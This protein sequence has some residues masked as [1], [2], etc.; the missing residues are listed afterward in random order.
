MLAVAHEAGLAARSPA[1]CCALDPL[2]PMQV[3][4]HHPRP[5][6]PPPLAA[7]LRECPRKRWRNRA[8]EVMYL[9]SR[10]GPVDPPVL[11]TPAAEILT[12]LN[13]LL[14][15][16]C[17][18]RDQPRKGP[19]QHGLRGHGHLRKHFAG[20]IVSENGDRE[21]INDLTRVRT[22]D[23]IVKRRATLLL[24]M[25]DGPIDR[26]TAAVPRQQRAMH[27]Q[28]APASA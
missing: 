23:H 20:I 11:R 21:L 22:V 14:T 15:S 27:V 2:H 17:R 28:R 24:A 6:N 9:L 12:R 5:V 1:R 10:A 26:R 25:K 4:L 19:R 16:G 13:A 7:H 18:P 3:V 8:H